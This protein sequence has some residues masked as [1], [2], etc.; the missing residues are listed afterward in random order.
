M[1]GLV[2]E[3]LQQPT[4]RRGERL[5]V[6]SHDRLDLLAGVEDRG[7]LVRRHA[8][9][10]GLGEFLFLVLEV[11][12]R[13]VG[14]AAH[15]FQGVGQALEVAGADDLILGGVEIGGIEQV[16]A[17]LGDERP[18][19]VERLR[20]EDG[21]R[22]RGG[23]ARRKQMNVGGVDLF[24]VDGG[25]PHHLRPGVGDE[26][27]VGR[28]VGQRLDLGV[29]DPRRRLEFQ[30]VVGR[31]LAGGG[32][33]VEP[34]ELVGQRLAFADEGLHALGELVAVVVVER[35]DVVDFGTL[36]VVGEDERGRAGL[37]DDLAEDDVPGVLLHDEAA[38][39]IA[40]FEMDDIIFPVVAAGG[41][42]GRRRGREKGGGQ[43]GRDEHGGRA[44]VHGGTAPPETGRFGR[45]T[46][47]P[48][49]PRSAAVARPVRP[50]GHERRHA[51]RSP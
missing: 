31:E 48:T 17:L 22:P 51:G 13:L 26:P 15:V 19:V 40:R 39:R 29:R 8:A 38:Q 37:A 18:V 16:A 36:N 43:D 34:F 44:A 11:G 42:I 5:L 27:E 45:A 46:S 20:E 2:V 35:V 33:G 6:L 12:E 50:Y 9:S 41:L 4:P 14:L 21:G 1:E 24:E 47:S 3:P 25:Q 10:E 49:I 32:V 30:A 23:D 28:L 7:Q